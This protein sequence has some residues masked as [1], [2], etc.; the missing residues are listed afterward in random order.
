[1][2]TE[3]AAEKNLSR[4]VGLRYLPE[5]G[6]PSVVLKSAGRSVEPVLD[7]ARRIGVPIVQDE[8]LLDSLYRLPTDAAIGRE[9]FE[10]VAA[11]LVHVYAL[12]D[13]IRQEE[14]A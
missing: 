1:V 2:R 3:V 6:P 9:L 8:R 10:L 4:A 7:R 5:G 13:A 11:L 14:E 12:D